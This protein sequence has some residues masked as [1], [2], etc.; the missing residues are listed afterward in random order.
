MKLWKIVM[1]VAGILLLVGCTDPEKTARHYGTGVYHCYGQNMYTGR[2]VKGKGD[3]K[4]DAEKHSMV[5]CDADAPDI[6][7]DKE[8]VI[9]DCIFK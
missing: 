1:T 2:L 4:P 6:H 3:E 8:C 9:V 7:D 5:L